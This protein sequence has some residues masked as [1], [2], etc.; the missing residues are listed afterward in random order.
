V[1]VTYLELK[2][3]EFLRRMPPTELFT[4]LE[5]AAHVGENVWSI[6]PRMK[7]LEEKELVWCDKKQG[8]NSNGH[9]RKM[10]GYRAALPGD[11]PKKLRRSVGPRVGDD[12]GFGPAFVLKE[13]C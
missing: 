13:D 4:S 1:D 11:Y 6:S 3:T 2:V 12:D 9:L 8:L 7:P 5:I 10:N